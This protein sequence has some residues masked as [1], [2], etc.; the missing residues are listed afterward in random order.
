MGAPAIKNKC[1]VDDAKIPDCKK[2]FRN[3]DTCEG[4]DDNKTICTF[5]KGAPAIK[6]KCEVDDAKKL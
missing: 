3:K 1:E 5:T 4:K 6:N 2:N